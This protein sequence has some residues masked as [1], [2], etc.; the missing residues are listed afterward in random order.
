MAATITSVVD[1]DISEPVFLVTRR[2]LAMLAVALTV[3]FGAVL[4]LILTSGDLAATLFG[5]G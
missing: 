1:P 2:E 5:P 3:V 4:L